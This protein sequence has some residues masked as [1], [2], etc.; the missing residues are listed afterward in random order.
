MLLVS[1]GLAGCSA[2]IE[3]GPRAIDGVFPA[4]GELP[5]LPFRVTDQT[6]L[7]RAIAVVNEDDVPEGVSQ[8]AGA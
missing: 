1:A 6:G 8:V 4:T 3:P 2:D 5:Q 7:I